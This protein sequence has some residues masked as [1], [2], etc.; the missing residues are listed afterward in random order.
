MTS[1]FI[2]VN[3]MGVVMLF[4]S[5]AKNMGWELVS[6]GASFPDAE[7]RLP[8][9]K[10]YRAEFEYVASN[11]KQHNHD[12]RKCDLIV[13]WENDFPESPLPILSLQYWQSFEMKE[14]T[15]EHKEIMYQRLENQRLRRQISTTHQRKPMPRKNIVQLASL[16]PPPGEGWR[17]ETTCQGR[18]FGYSV[19]RV[20]HSSVHCIQKSD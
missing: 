14:A 10:I 1:Q 3:E 6:I 18:Y 19:F 2:P 13:C 7:I 17:L 4:G 20:E 8:D 15:E 12:P 11:F 16:T 9:G 5:I